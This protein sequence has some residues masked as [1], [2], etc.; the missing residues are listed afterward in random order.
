MIE[1]I[2]RLFDSF[3]AFFQGIWDWLTDGLYDFAVWVFRGYVEFATL[4]ALKFKL[5]VLT[6]AWDVA[7]AI[8][9]DLEVSTRLQALYDLLPPS[10]A[11]NI[12]AMRIPEGVGLILTAYVTRYVLRFIPGGRE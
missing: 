11:V 8:L 2:Q 5:F 10:V 1:A 3:I 7:K 4:G 6:F 9:V 12:T